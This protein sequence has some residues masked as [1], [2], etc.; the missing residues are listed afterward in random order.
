MNDVRQSLLFLI[1]F[2]KLL[3]VLTLCK[4]TIDHGV[5]EMTL[6]CLVEINRDI[7]L[8]KLNTICR[9]WRNEKR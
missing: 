5:V 7:L 4:K 9:R 6:T 3:A 8:D 2:R 1:G